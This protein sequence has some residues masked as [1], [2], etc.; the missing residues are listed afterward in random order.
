MVKRESGRNG[1]R[2]FRDLI[3]EVRYDK[4]KNKVGD[5]FFFFFLK[6]LNSNTKGFG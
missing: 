2:E 1:L 4:G 3:S 5:S 6:I